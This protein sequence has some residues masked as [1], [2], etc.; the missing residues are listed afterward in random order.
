MKPALTSVNSR[1]RA[2][3]ILRA[4]AVVLVLGRHMWLCPVET[5]AGM[6]RF[7]EIWFNGGWLG[8]DLFFVLSG[9]L[10]SGLLFREYARHGRISLKSFLIRRGFK[11]YPAF[12]L[13]TA[14]T[15]IVRLWL[16]EPLNKLAVA[17]EFLFLQN[18]GPALWNHTWSLAVE[19]HFYFFLVLLL[20]L[21]TIRRTGAN[22]FRLVPVVFA[23][24]ALTCLGLR[25]LQWQVSPSWLARQ[26]LYPTHL[27]MD[28]LFAG[29]LIAYIHQLR[30]E[31]LVAWARRWRWGLVSAGVLVLIPAFVLSRSGSMFIPTIG[32]TL[33]YCGGG[34][35]LL[36]ALSAADLVRGRLAAAIAYVGSHSYSIYLWHMPVSVWVVPRLTEALH[37]RQNWW[38]YFATYILGSVALGI[39][40]ANVIEFPMLRLRDRL[41]PSRAR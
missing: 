6:H 4:L 23:T 29:V 35:L 3:D 38:A 25:L 17:C 2:I 5:S 14:T 19:E 27:R 40:L 22:P 41:F 20:L 13:L 26:Q 39:L 11:I 8:V 7:T 24:L 32:L 9:Y 34:L 28:S 12:W 36:A 18:Y 31:S 30:G 1:S 37:V 33:H 10:V 15:V 21:L 16:H